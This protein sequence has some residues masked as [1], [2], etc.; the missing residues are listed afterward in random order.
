M[1][2]MLIPELEL[3]G[4]T[5]TLIDSAVLGE[6]VA[7]AK[8]AE[9]CY[10]ARNI[11]EVIFLKK[12]NKFFHGVHMT[13]DERTK[14]CAKLVE[15]G[16]KDESAMRIINCIEKAASNRIVDYLINATRSLLMD[17]ISVEEYF[18]IINALVNTIEE[19]LLFLQK[20]ISDSEELE[21]NIATNGL[22]LSGLLHQSNITWDGKISYKITFLGYLVDQ[23]AVSFGDDTR[24]PN[25]LK[26]TYA[27]ETM[28]TEVET[29]ISLAT[30][31][32]IEEMF[33]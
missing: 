31:E 9:V 1:Y 12:L 8:L 26:R 30:E 19:D 3:L 6:A 33:K 13:E 22:S 32:D 7:L 23:Y 11:K 15:Y 10:K 28:K 4:N 5:A 18:R 29:N 14:L 27:D 25:P 2:N 17:Y 20:H 16:D 24:Y 21:Y